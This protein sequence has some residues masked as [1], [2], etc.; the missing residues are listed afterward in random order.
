M[1][2]NLNGKCEGLTMI[3]DETKEKAVELLPWTAPD[4]T[5]REVGVSTKGGATLTTFDG[6]TNPG[7]YKPMAS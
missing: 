3:K 7:T 5:T 1:T 2:T 4:Y 6:D